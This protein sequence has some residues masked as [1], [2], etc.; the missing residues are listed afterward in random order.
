MFGFIK[1]L[2]GSNKEPDT[3]NYQEKIKETL[4]EEMKFE[5]DTVVDSKNKIDE[6]KK[7]CDLVKNTKYHQQ[8]QKVLDITS[9]I[10][11]KFINENLPKLK[12]AQFHIYYTDTFIDTYTALTKELRKDEIETIKNVNEPKVPEI[13]YSTDTIKDMQTIDTIKIVIEKFGLKKLNVPKDLDKYDSGSRYSNGEKY[14]YNSILVE[15][16]PTN[17]PLYSKIKDGK[18]IGECDKY[19]VVFH[20]YYVTRKLFFINQSK[21]GDIYVVDYTDI[22]VYELLNNQAK[23]GYVLSNYKLDGE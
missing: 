6:L 12:L 8:F 17:Y 11:D 5:M 18:F 22:D 4:G 20:N 19:A 2:I 14:L 9:S 15:N 3:T 7:L 16:V 23:K 13:L 1:K 21:K 10:H